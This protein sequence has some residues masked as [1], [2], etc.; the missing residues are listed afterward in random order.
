MFSKFFFN[1]AVLIL[2][3]ISL[4]AHA[5]I[6]LKVD[7]VS[8]PGDTISPDDGTFTTVT[9]A[10]T[11]TN[12]VVFVLPTTENSDSSTLRIQNITA[13]SF[14]VAVS[15]PPQTFGGSPGVTATT[16]HYIVI[17]AGS[18]NLGGV[19]LEAGNG[20]S[21]AVLDTDAF[22]GRNVPFAVE[23][24]L[25]FTFA[26]TYPSNPV[27]LSQV[28]SANNEILKPLA[29]SEK[30]LETVVRFVSPTT[31]Q[32]G[33]ERAETSANIIS[34]ENIGYLAISA[35]T[36][37]S[38]TDDGGSSINFQSILTAD[39][40]THNCTNFAFDA[41][42]LGSNP[43]VV[44]SQNSRDGGDGGWIKR[45][46]LTS[47]QVGFL[48]DEDQAGDAEKGHT[49]EIAGALLFSG[50]FDAEIAAQNFRMEAGTVTT[51]TETSS[52]PIVGTLAFVPVAFP[53]PF[54]TDD[55]VVLP[56]P[57]AELAAPV[58][59]RIKNVDRNGFEIAQVQPSGETILA[60]AMDVDY[61]AIEAG[62]YNLPNN[63][64]LEAGTLSTS[65][66]ISKASGVTIPLTF[67]NTFASPPV[68]LAHIQ[69]VNNEPTLDPNVVSD[70]WL[71]VATSSVTNTQASVALERAET[72][73]TGSS[74]SLAEEI[75]YLA[76]TPSIQQSFLDD[77]GNT[78]F[79]ETLITGNNIGGPSNSPNC[80]QNNFVSTFTT[81]SVRAVATPRTRNG[82]D[83]FWFVKCFLN[84]TQIGMYA[85]EDRTLDTDR[86]HA[87]ETA[88]I[89]AFDQSFES[90]LAAELL[91][92][93]TVAVVSDPIN[94]TS[95]PKAISGAQLEY[96]VTIE[97]PRSGSTVNDTIVIEDALPTE[98]ELFVGVGATTSPFTITNNTDEGAG[99]T[100]TFSSFTSFS[101][102]LDS[103]E[104]SNDNGATFNY[105]PE[106]PDNDGYDP[107][108]THFRI[109][110][111][112][113]I[114]GGF[115]GYTGNIEIN[116][117]ARLK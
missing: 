1:A 111:T 56:L 104:F 53:N 18:Y 39:S 15:E 59:V 54:F 85:E 20:T 50:A 86:S 66:T 49:T 95:N 60:D 4:Y 73:T 98:V 113:Y 116:Y 8:L 114:G 96:T 83:G 35:N 112:G 68:F 52:G 80:H 99:N 36:T 92:T 23:G 63:V 101:D 2:G 21:D 64:L 30:F 19:L 57:S 28:Q 79:Y 37:G 71:T 91:P 102:P 84:D 24:T 106:D 65:N 6:R 110:P 78:I 44:A 32:F 109:T 47:T 13:N 46:A 5:D 29:V 105:T 69:T 88:S 3:V 89:L 17:E 90:G 115:S 74:V 77:S 94:L 51:P 70:P 41:A 58:G 76:I 93:K 62:T 45:C 12:P 9:L 55:V 87:N 72:Y 10:N 97:N 40:I 61:I 48:V 42:T 82:T 7:R 22:L 103:Y 11:Y 107:A 31:M 75:G 117:T 33:L 27:V 108:V 14:D 38:I 81:S 25:P 26:N 16:V 43:L 67:A 100:L 34:N